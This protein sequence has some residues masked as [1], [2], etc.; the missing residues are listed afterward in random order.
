MNILK[1]VLT[2]HWFEKIESGEKTH[3]YRQCTK[4][5]ASRIDKI[6]CKLP[7]MTGEDWFVEFQKA[8][9]KDAQKMMFRISSI[10]IR[11]G[12]DTDLKIDDKVYDIGLGERIK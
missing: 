5:W 9:R 6:F 3:E 12:K 7:C 11:N 2:D 4:H 10:R 1:L 8:Y